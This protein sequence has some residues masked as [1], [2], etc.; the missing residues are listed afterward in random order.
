MNQTVES[1]EKNCSCSAKTPPLDLAGRIRERLQRL[2]PRQRAVGEFILSNPACPAFFTINRLAEKIGVS[3]STVF[4]FSHALG[5]NGY[6]HLVMESRLAVQSIHRQE[7]R[8]PIVETNNSCAGRGRDESRFARMVRSE[9]EN[10]VNMAGTHPFHRWMKLAERMATADRIGVIGCGTAAGPAGFFYQLCV[11]RF[12]RIEIFTAADIPALSKVNTFDTGSLVFFL[13]FP[14]HPPEGV[15]LAALAGGRGS[16]VVVITDTPLSPAVQPA[17]E[18]FFMDVRAPSFI[19]GFT[20]PV[21]F[22]GALVTEAGELVSGMR[23][24]GRSSAP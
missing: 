22:F 23:E 21:A 17:D 15:E 13:S 1:T 11:I 9:I 10:L 2:T 19:H 6:T 7:N 14:P 16:H 20:A 24:S 12:P 3:P 8:V 4:R 18:T 5:F